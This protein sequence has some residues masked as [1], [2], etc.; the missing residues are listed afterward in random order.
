MGKER[1]R[2]IDTARF[3]AMAMVFY[4]HF[5]ERIMYLAN[6]TAAAQYKFIYSFHMVLFFVLAGYVAKQ[7][8]LAPGFGRFLKQ[9]VL[10]RLLPFV[11]FT[12]VFMLAAGLFPGDFFQLQL[13]SVQGYIDGL[14]NTVFGIPMFCVP[15]WFL[16]IIFSVEMIHYWAFR[17]L[18]SDVKIVA[19]VILF[20][21]CGYLLNAT[22]DIVNPIRGRVVG[23][24]Y[25]FIHEALFM[26]AFYLLGVF[27]RR[28]RFLRKRQPLRVLAPAAMAAFLVVLFTYRLNSGRFSFPPLDAVVILFSSHGHAAWFPLTALAGCLMVLLVAR[29]VPSWRPMVWMGQNTL[30]LMCLNGIFYHYINPPVAAWVVGHLPGTPLTVWWVGCAMTAGSLAVCMPLVYLLRRWLPQLVGRPAAAGPLL[31]NLI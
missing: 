30:I 13:P 26:Y 18:A 24:N 2:F 11:F 4:G 29:A 23:W 10:S 22:F 7:D 3:L 9:R 12:L 27:L 25:L 16:L 21:V 1:I 5:I 31:K 20:Y 19:G 8:D 28:Q 15:S 6:P 14:V 17:L